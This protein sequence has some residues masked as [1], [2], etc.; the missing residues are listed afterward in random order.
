MQSLFI[1]PP[2]MYSPRWQQ[3]FP[4]AQYCSSESELPAELRDLLIWVVLGDEFTLE[5]IKVWVAAGARV[6]GLTQGENSYQAK[7]TIEA[8]ASG[9][10]HYL[11]V[12]P[13]LEQV[14]QV[15]CV[16]GLWLGVELMRQL[17]LAT[18]TAIQPHKKNVCLD[19]LS[20]RELAVANAV[21][22]GKTNKEVA[23]QLDITERTVKA[24]LSAIFE[25]LKVRD[26][27]QLVL[28]ISGY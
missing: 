28:I 15:V 2:H 6:I 24:H 20:T 9:Y 11:A 18:T 1:S 17:M 12:V 22:A 13:V 16:G 5:H 27:L 19:A 3:A 10:L 7:A 23:R 26:R 14:Y 8:G 4:A 25:K 21:A